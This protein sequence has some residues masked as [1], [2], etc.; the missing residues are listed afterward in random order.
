[1]PIFWLIVFAFFF[2]CGAN[3]Q[4]AVSNPCVPGMICCETPQWYLQKVNAIR[5]EIGLTAIV[6]I[7][8]GDNY[9]TYSDE[10]LPPNSTTHCCYDT[11]LCS[12][13][14]FCEAQ[15]EGGDL[16]EG[17][18]VVAAIVVAAFLVVGAFVF[19][20]FRADGSGDTVRRAK[21]D[22]Q[23]RALDKYA[24]R[25]DPTAPRRAYHFWDLR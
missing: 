5:D 15:I 8:D 11:D 7:V 17:N 1:M 22:Q 16:G 20:C 24:V 4:C 21:A 18:A 13:Y 10:G 9:T 2:V 3:G 6:T 12:D 14:V 25:A 19:F 23:R